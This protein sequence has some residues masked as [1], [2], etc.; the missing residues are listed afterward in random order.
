MKKSLLIAAV[1][2]SGLL[3]YSCQGDAPAGAW[4]DS[5]VDSL[6]N[7]IIDSVVAAKNREHDSLMMDYQTRLADSLRIVDSITKATGKA[8]TS[9]VVRPSTPKPSTNN[10]PAPEAEPTKPEPTKP[11]VTDRPGAKNDGTPKSVTDRPGAKNDGT[12][13]SVNDRSGA[14]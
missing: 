11:T 10:K 3:L 1:A 9:V 8:P 2:A 12:P 7:A 13:K 4:T 14:K 6:K 5:R